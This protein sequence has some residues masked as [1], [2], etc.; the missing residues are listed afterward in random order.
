MRI[1][2]CLPVPKEVKNIL[3]EIMRGRLPVPYINVTNL[4][5]T[6]NF[7]GELTDD[8]VRKV[9]EV[10]PALVGERRKQFLIEFDR[11]I[12]FRQQIHL[13]LKENNA[14]RIMQSDLEKGFRKNNLHRE[15]RT[16][17]PHIKLANMHI[18]NTMYRERKF[19]NFPNSELSQLNFTADVVAIYE[20]KLLLHHAHHKPLLGITLV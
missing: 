8:E 19:I 11:L 18:D 12:N 5:I 20:S 4:H 17:Y 9:L 14:L 10:F 3:V 1:F 6:L 7:L 15:D 2:T 13:T 16:Y